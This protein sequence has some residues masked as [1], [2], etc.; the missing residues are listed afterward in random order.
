[1]EFDSEFN[2]FGWADILDKKDWRH[3]RDKNLNKLT[4]YIDSQK[5]RS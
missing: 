2:V 1:M 3:N 4:D 5:K